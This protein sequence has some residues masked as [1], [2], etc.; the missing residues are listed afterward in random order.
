MINLSDYGLS[1]CSPRVA[2]IGDVY[3]RLTILAMGSRARRLVHAVCQCECGN[4]CRPTLTNLRRGTATSCGCYRTELKKAQLG[5]VV[6][7]GLSFHPI[8]KVWKGMMAR[9][10]TRT[11]VHYDSYGGRGITVCPEWVDPHVFIE[12][13]YP[14][15][16]PGLTLDRIDNDGD[17]SPSNCRWATWK[18]QGANKR[19]NKW[20]THNGETKTFSQWAE[21]AGV[22]KT[23]VSRRIAKGKPPL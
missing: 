5:K 19:S 17:Y 1:P 2:K 15:Y 4:I 10:F 21:I 22:N 3:G 6:T 13:M 12:D 20:F 14:T 8:F 23:T 7:H 18:E 9:C 11:H 16:L